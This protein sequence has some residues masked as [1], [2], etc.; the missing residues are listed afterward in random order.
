MFFFFFPFPVTKSKGYLMDSKQQAGSCVCT[1]GQVH[2][3]SIK[4]CLQLQHFFL[5]SPQTVHQILEVVH[6]ITGQLFC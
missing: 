5:E 4:H 1:V 2:A 6:D 3:A